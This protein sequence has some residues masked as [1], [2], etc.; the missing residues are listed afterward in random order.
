MSDVKRLQAWFDEGRLLRPDAKAPSTVHLARALASMAGATVD[1]DGPARRVLEAIGEADHIVFVL[2]DGLG[3]D[4]VETR[5]AVSVLRRGLAMELRSVFPSS[6]APALT[7][8]ATG[9]WPGEHAVTTWQVYL[10]DLQ[11]HVTSLPYVERFSEKP[12]DEV[13]VP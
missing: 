5:D 3:M 9:L 11:R 10:P 6:T 12:A 7:S 1:I 13:G 4:L 8:L 2:A